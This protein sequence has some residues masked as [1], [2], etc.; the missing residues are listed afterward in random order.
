MSSRLTLPLALLSFPV[1]AAAPL[2]AQQPRPAAR[3]ATTAAPAA[4][5][6]VTEEKRGLFAK[7]KITAAAA[8][9]TALASVPGSHM[10]KGELEEE[11]GKLI[12]SFDLKVPGRRGIK[13]VHVDALTGAVI[14]TEE[15]EDAPATKAPTKAP[16]ATK[17]PAPTRPPARD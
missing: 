9:A 12:Y 5:P 1:L 8:T 13:E 11:D 3:P 7:A 4:A 16:A 14:R 6:Q 15:E 17:A 2:A 10:T